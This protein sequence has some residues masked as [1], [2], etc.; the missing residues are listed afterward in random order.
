MPIFLISLPVFETKLFKLFISFFKVFGIFDKEPTGSLIASLAF[1]LVS[2]TVFTT[3]KRTVNIAVVITPKI[4]KITN[5]IRKLI[6]W[7]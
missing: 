7:I 1:L 5:N 6:N 3:L 2:S 4:N